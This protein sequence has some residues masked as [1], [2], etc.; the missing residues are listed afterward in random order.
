M[1]SSRVSI[2][3]DERREWSCCY[4]M[5]QPWL[6]IDVWVCFESVMGFPTSA[7]DRAVNAVRYMYV[8][9]TYFN[10]MRGLKNDRTFGVPLAG[11]SIPLDDT[12][13]NWVCCRVEQMGVSLKLN[14]SLTL[15][16]D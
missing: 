6:E 16:D 8:L 11:H 2:G 1:S 10:V 12:W 4:L 9:Y 14:H 7:S 13:P 5:K 3:C 15:L